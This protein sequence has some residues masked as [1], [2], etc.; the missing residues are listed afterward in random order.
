MRDDIVTEIG[1]GSEVRVELEKWY[2]LT[3]KLRDMA[4]TRFMS[5]MRT[6]PLTRGR[7]ATQPG[8]STWTW[9]PT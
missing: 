7:G 8:R 6:R 1:K 4:T 3:P 5:T 9:A 2:S